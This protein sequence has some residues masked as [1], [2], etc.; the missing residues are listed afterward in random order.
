[1]YQ[2]TL[3]LLAML[4]ITSCTQAQKPSKTPQVSFNFEQITPIIK[5]EAEWQK[6]LP[7]DVYEIARQ[8]GTERAFTGKYW[9]NHQ[10]GIYSCTACK[11]PLFSSA[12]KFDSGTGWPSY[13]QPIHTK[14][15]RLEGDSS[16]GMV[17]NEVLCSRC[18]AH[19]GHVFD[20][21][22]KPTG[23][24]YCINGNVLDFVAQ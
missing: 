6:I 3:C 16:H 19:L 22:P 12:T 10:A 15:I 9:N 13:Y 14:C 5:T 24:R 20:D 21:G 11:L 4:C 2:Y 23:L 1:M 8:K 7:P 18:G 17:R